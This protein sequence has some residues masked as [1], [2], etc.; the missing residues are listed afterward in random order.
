MAKRVL[1]YNEEEFISLLEN[2]VKKVKS[3]EKRLDEAKKRPSARNINESR[4]T[5]P[6]KNSNRPSPYERFK[7][8][9]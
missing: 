1:R 4:R 3:E 2:I 8:L 7:K 5:N 9:R 6:V